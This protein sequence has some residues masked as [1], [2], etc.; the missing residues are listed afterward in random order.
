MRRLLLVV[1]ALPAVAAAQPY[2]YEP[3][4]MLNTAQDPFPFYVDGRAAMPAGLDVN[5]VRIASEAAWAAWNAVGCAAPK[6]VGRG[7]TGTTVQHP[8]DTLDVYS[9][10]PVWLLDSTDPDFQSIIGPGGLVASLSIIESYAG[11]LKTC[12]TFLNGAT[13][14]WSLSATPPALA[15]DVQTVLM[16][17]AG[18]CLGLDHFGPSSNV[19]YPSVEAGGSKRLLGSG[20]VQALCDR[21][22]ST[23]VVG[24]PCDAGCGA[25]AALTCLDQPLT[26]GLSQKRCS[27]PCALGTNDGTC[28]LPMTCQ[29]TAAIPGAT[30]ACLL[31]GTSVT[32]V[33]APCTNAVQDCGSA[34]AFCQAPTPAPSGATFWAGG[35]CSQSCAAGHPACPAGAGCLDLGQGPVCLQSCRVGLAD[36]RAGYACADLGTGTGLCIPQCAENQ[37]CADTTNYFCRACDGLCV[38]KNNVSGQVGDLCQ[39]DSQCGPGQI[40]RAVSATSATKLCTEQCSRG[41]GVCPAGATCTPLAGGELYCLKDCSGPFTCPSGLQCAATAVGTGCLP[42]CSLETDCPVG[43]SCELGQCVTPGDGSV[44]GALCQR[45]DSGHPITPLPDAGGQDPGGS[46]GCG[47]GGAPDLTPVLLAAALVLVTRRSRWR[48]P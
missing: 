18:H 25:N 16:H 29:A 41:C 40:C 20:D 19:M 42:P 24:A 31:P 27:T 13:A 36:C 21:N 33:G 2:A 34:A 11:V 26:D 12:D 23:G 15:Y 35:Y 14:A 48:A 3:W 22:P 4:R 46:A 45:P 30:A 6:A 32:L 7:L 8:Q 17:E 38:S 1:A 28:P 44:C 37:D 47:C 39:D 9:V 43:Q 10:M 5:G